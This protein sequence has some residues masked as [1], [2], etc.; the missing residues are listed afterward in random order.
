MT[1]SL[2]SVE[3]NRRRLVGTRSRL[4]DC[5]SASWRATETAKCASAIGDGCMRYWGAST[6]HWRFSKNEAVK[7]LSIGDG[8]TL[9]FEQT[10]HIDGTQ[11]NKLKGKLY[12]YKWLQTG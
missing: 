7:V 12:E 3:A 5:K 8:V 11:Q 2:A 4:I 10:Q 1:R 9:E 6:T